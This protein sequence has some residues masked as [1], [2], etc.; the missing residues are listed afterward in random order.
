MSDFL[1]GSA[2]A[3]TVLVAVKMSGGPTD[4]YN[5]LVNKLIESNVFLAR[6]YVQLQQYQPDGVWLVHP[7]QEI[8]DSIGWESPRL[9]E[10]VSWLRDHGFYWGHRDGVAVYEN[11]QM[12]LMIG[13]NPWGR[14]RPNSSEP[15][16]LIIRCHDKKNSS[17]MAPY[18]TL[19][20]GSPDIA[21]LQRM[22]G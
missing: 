9:R 18:F 13:G 2:I 8:A 10:V 17:R 15:S 21:K 6:A 12:Y 11:S 7:D 3:L 16:T 5:P 14:E 22:V 19:G 4:H 1:I 20:D